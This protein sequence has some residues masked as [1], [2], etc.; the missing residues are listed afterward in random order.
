MSA[1]LLQLL[2]EVDAQPAPVGQ[3]LLCQSCLVSQL[4]HLCANRRFRRTSGFGA[5]A[6][7]RI[8]GTGRTNRLPVVP[9]QGYATT[10]AQSRNDRRHYATH[11]AHDQPGSPGFGLLVTELVITG[12]ALR[13]SCACRL[14]DQQ[15]KE[16]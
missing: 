7:R 8:P 15:R 4:R 9:A 13:A 12:M 6:P 1:H 11:G 5:I 16:R 2:N 3:L 10:G 14:P